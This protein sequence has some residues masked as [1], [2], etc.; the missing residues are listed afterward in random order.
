ML[1]LVILGLKFLK[2]SVL[3]E[4][5][6]LILVKFQNFTEIALFG[7]LWARFKKKLLSYLKSVT[8]TLYNSKI[9]QEIKNV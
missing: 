4:V 8:S 3:F 5:S 7:N 9:L 6:T 1:Y 2:A